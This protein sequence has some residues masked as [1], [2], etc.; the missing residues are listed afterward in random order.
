M[1]STIQSRVN[2]VLGNRVHP[3]KKASHITILV[4]KKSNHVVDN[5]SSTRWVKRVISQ[6]QAFKQEKIDPLFD[7]ERLKQMEEMSLDEEVLSEEQQLADQMF[8]FSSAMLL[9]TAVAVALYP[10]S[11]FLFIPPI[12]FMEIPFFKEAYQ[13]L[14]ERKITTTVVDA[15]LSISS[16]GYTIIS[17]PIMLMAA[18]AGWVHSYT[19]KL[20]TSS[21]DGTRKKLTNLFGQQPKHVWVMRDGIEVSV[22]FETVQMG[23]YVVIEAGQ[24]VPVDGRI[25]EGMASIDQHMLTGE[26]QPA[27]KGIGDSVFAATVVLAGRIV[28]QV[29]KTGAETAAAQVGQILTE[30]SNFTSGVQLRGKEI[31]D[32]AAGP[33]LLLSILALPLVGP[34]RTLAILFSGIGYNMKILGPLSVMNYL[35]LTSQVGV[36]IKDGRALE[37]VGKVDIVV[38]DKTGTLTQEVPHVGQIFTVDGCD[39]QKLL[40]YAAAAEHRQTHPIAKAI[41]QEAEARDLSVPP[42]SEAA[43]EIGY[44]IKVRLE[45]ELVRVGSYRFMQMEAL[46]IPDEMAAIQQNSHA[47][48]NSLIYI[49]IDGQLAGAIELVP[50]VRPEAKKIVEY[51]HQAG[52][53]TAIISGDH[54]QPTRSLA[55]SLG[56]DHYFA[57][58]LPENKADLIEQLQAEGKSVCFVGD[59]INDSI[60]LQK[61]NVSISL[62]GA[63]T[64]ATDT[65]QIILMDQT[66]NQLE[67]LFELSKQF[68]SNMY[69]NLMSTVVPGVIII[70]GAFVGWIGYGASIALFSVGLAAG[71]T[72][73]MRPLFRQ[74]EEKVH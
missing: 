62:R 47:A 36:L 48:G 45:E 42:I 22:P 25:H 31:A 8:K 11:I 55:S 26:A 68:E 23:D 70:G 58:T 21:K 65:A 53:E 74:I 13:D 4:G 14:R 9:T 59:G 6:M 27:E 19:Q 66:L 43:Y 38:F 5:G 72:N 3:P 40:T 24:M 56:I 51:V 49:A 57:E 35:Q 50:T 18:M 41:L 39:E 71:V 10:P 64:I 17:P 52:L 33:T 73:A 60:A 2:Q 32:R 54:E 29:E 46:S 44:G 30:T 15:T 34:S 63:S 1:L 69:T 67:A 20:V 28:V 12:I 61:T 7:D 16:L 37:Q